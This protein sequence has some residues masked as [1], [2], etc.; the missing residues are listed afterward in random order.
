M[1]GKNGKNFTG[2]EVNDKY[3]KKYINKKI[4][5][6]NS[7]INIFKVCWIRVSHRSGQVVFLCLRYL[8]GS[9]GE[10]YF[11]FFF[12]TFFQEVVERQDSDS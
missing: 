4:Y 1:A 10:E 6:L 12:F 9:P 2:C 3:D 8:I 5:I 11:F 7:K